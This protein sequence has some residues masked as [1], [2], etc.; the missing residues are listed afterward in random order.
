M[1]NGNVLVRVVRCLLVT[2]LVLLSTLTLEPRATQAQSGCDVTKTGDG[3][4]LRW[5]ERCGKV[6]LTGTPEAIAREVLAARATALGL[7][8]DGR[9]LRLLAVTPTAVA[10]HVR[11]AQ[12]HKGVPVYLGQVL[13]QYGSDG[14]VQLINNHTLP[15]LDVDVT[16][17]ISAADAEAAALTQVSGSDR[18]RAP[19]G[20]ELV[21][22]G[23]GKAPELA[24]HIT[25]FTS[26]PAGDWH[27]MVSAQS[28]AV[29]SA[30]DEIMHD[31]GSGL[32][33]NPNAVQQSG[34]TSLRDNADATS[35]A[36]DSAR[37]NL[38]LNH[39]SAATHQLKGS[40][41][42]ITGVGV[43]GCNLPYSPGL[44]NEPTRIYNYTRDDDRFEE[45]NVYAAIDGVQ[46][47]FQSLGFTNVNN[48]AIPVNVHCFAADNS[49]YSPGDK[50]LHFGDGGVDDAEDSD[51]AVHE[52]GH[53]VQ[54]NQVPGWGPG[55]NTEQR[56]MG[57][58][59]GDFLTG[60][61]SISKG[62]PAYLNT[63]R[64]CIGEWDATAYNPAVGGNAGSGCLRWINGRDEGTGADIGVYGGAPSEEHDDG[65]YWSAALTCMYEGMGANTAARDKIIKLVLQHHF[66][67]TPDTSNQAF[68]NAVDALRLADLNLFGSAD[69]TLIVN[70]AI[71]R[72]LIVMPQL[73]APTI[74]APTEGATIVAGSPIT[75]TWNINGAPAS[76]TYRIES[77]LCDTSTIFS[78][79]VESGSPG[80]TTSHTG[81]SLDWTQ[82]T[83]ST[84]SP[85]H[86]WFAGDEGA[87]NDQYLVG[88]ALPITS[89][90]E[91]I[92]WHRYDLEDG[93]DGG[94]VEVSTN[95]GGSWSDL[96]SRMTH[97]GYTLT[98]A[99]GSTSPITGRPAFSGNSG[100]WVETRA[101]L[102]DFMGQTIQLRFREADD[103]SVAQIGWWVDDIR[104]ATLIPWTPVV[105]TT[106]GATSFTWVTPTTPGNYCLRLRGQAP[107]YTDSSYSPVRTFSLIQLRKVYLPVVIRP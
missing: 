22:Y 37:V 70:C 59:F 50:S 3:G 29:L 26:M 43:A 72:N 32:G 67:L 76:A 104:L 73:F 58:G 53:S 12:V 19:I 105:T 14:A 89:S 8:P 107:G 106:M 23:E 54:D 1:L 28:G 44:A 87:T 88:P 15:N 27:V 77:A 86:S 40:Y 51:I 20:H 74:T 49:N 13:V 11:F 84:H 9:D 81:G 41:V 42:D 46:S 102:S 96:G 25:L 34:D 5:L 85:T 56:A 98:I 47:W 66:S 21:I 63:Y 57:E 65:R 45:V 2:L 97:N 83:T 33:Y 79:T 18:L 90:E 68:E 100:G 10:T 35:A 92:F 61:Y 6:K 69:Q 62:N 36:L 91:L 60:M 31:S 7:R 16:P 55:S 48:R 94:V 75:I 4:T 64:Y 80:W 17:V 71:A 103:D 82:V 99:S 24:W 38:T 93:Y 95:G 30:W 52:Y 39:L 101:N 78:D